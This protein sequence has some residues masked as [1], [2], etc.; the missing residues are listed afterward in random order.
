MNKL[1]HANLNKKVIYESFFCSR[2]SKVSYDASCDGYGV[3]VISSKVVGHATLARVH[4]S[5]AQSLFVDDF[6]RGGFHERGA[7]QEYP[8]LLSDDDIF[9]GHGRDIGTTFTS[10]ITNQ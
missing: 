6:S 5:A 9:V 3:F 2:R 7:R 8:A 1:A 4:L 10:V